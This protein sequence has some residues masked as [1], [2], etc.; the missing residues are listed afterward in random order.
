MMMMVMTMG[1]AL[2]VAAFSEVASLTSMTA[3]ITMM[4]M[5][6]RVSVSVSVNMSGCYY[7][8]PYNEQQPSQ[9]QRVSLS[10]PPHAVDSQ[11][12]D[13]SVAADPPA[14]TGYIHVHGYLNLRWDSYQCAWEYDD[15]DDDDDDD[16]RC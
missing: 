15:D 12:D 3:L 8:T 10:L 9:L 11:G 2:G 16:E 5:T 1:N 4:M 7:D 6:T 14:S 13:A